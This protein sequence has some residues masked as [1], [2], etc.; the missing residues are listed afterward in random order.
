MALCSDSYLVSDSSQISYKSSRRLQYDIHLRQSTPML[1]Y[2]SP[3]LN[4][5]DCMSG[6]SGP[7]RSRVYPL[8]KLSISWIHLVT[9]YRL[10]NSFNACQLNAARVFLLP[11]PGIICSKSIVTAC[12]SANTPVAS[13]KQMVKLTKV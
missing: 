7:V 9:G 6:L 12:L 13:P 8:R 10:S 11:R 5:R 1:A 2:V 3:N 4:V